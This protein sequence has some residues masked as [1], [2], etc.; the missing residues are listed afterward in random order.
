M[1]SLSNYRRWLAAVAL[2]LLVAVSSKA[3]VY[4][5][6]PAAQNP[7][8]G[9]TG[10]QGTISSPPPTQAATIVTPVNGTSVSGIPITVTGLCKT[11]LLVKLFTN[12]VFVGSVLCANGSYSLSID[13]FS[14]ENDL[15][16]RVYDSLDQAGPDSNKVVV[17]FTDGQFN[18]FGSRVT[19]TSDYARR[20]ADPNAELDWPILLSGGTPPYAISVDWGDGTAAELISQSS[21][22]TVTIKHTYKNAG[23]YKVIVKATDK[24]GTSAYLQLVGVAN[25]QPTS[26]SGTSSSSNAQVIT[27]TKLIWW[28]VLLIIPF[29][30]LAFWLGRRHELYTLRRSLEN[31]Q[32]K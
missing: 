26:G 12:N 28:P 22:G 29:S 8:S 10:L 25:G 2:C 14:G 11:G 1:S 7:Q 3:P 21:P 13:L 18:Q 24:N 20:G 31:R 23:V 5:A 16:A 32:K 30:L 19:L 17:N 27:K 15:I 9:S 6:A 4:A